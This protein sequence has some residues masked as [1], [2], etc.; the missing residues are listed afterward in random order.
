MTFRIHALPAQYFSPLCA[1][2][3]AELA[4]RN[5][6][7][8]R[9]AT[10][11]GT[12]CRVGLADIPAGAT[13][14]LVNYRHHRA[15]GPYRAAHAI[16]VQEGAIRARPAPGTVPQMLRTRLISLRGFD[17]DGMM[18]EAAIAPGTGLEA[19]ILDAFGDPRTTELHL[20]FAAPGCYAAR[21]TRD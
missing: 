8:V 9:V 2:S 14:L 6:R 21:V 1:L 19:A 5:A 3:D 17:R 16:F 18:T 11:P 13:A 20:H 7:R 10:C 4:R 15:A 12:P